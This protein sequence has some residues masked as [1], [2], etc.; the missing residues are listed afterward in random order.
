M[1]P[2]E[3]GVVE[4]RA[5]EADATSVDSDESSPSLEKESHPVSGEPWVIEPR[6][7]GLLAQVREAW[8]YRYLV[9]FFGRKILEK[10][11]KRTKLGFWWLI[12]R[13][14]FPVL[15]STVVFGGV[16][17]VEA[18]GGVPYFLFL[19]AG[20]MQWRSFGSGL[21]W[22]TRSLELNRGLMKQLYFPRLILP[23]ST[24][25]L[26]WLELVIY[27]VILTIAIGYYKVVD[28]I[29][30]LGS[31]LTPLLAL[32]G[33]L[34]GMFFAFSVGLFTSILGAQTRDLRFSLGY[35]LNAWMLLTPVVYP[36]D[37]IP[38]QWRWTVYL[39]PMAAYVETFKFGLLGIGELDVFGLLL[40]V[41][42]T[43]T[44][45]AA[46]LWFFN[47]SAVTSADRL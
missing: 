31:G 47:R 4:A 32:G 15:I 28:G 21:M 35:I 23:F 42:L 36:L 33:V 34:M 13:P 44:L 11:T 9:R 2:H 20:M 30:Y 1:P 16:M 5:R 39:N 43:V 41:V 37:W 25:T 38:Q 19:S 12:I 29:L 24:M 8:R 45:F 3:T 26:A 14:V 7:P 27:V 6:A 18:P 22:C 10:R 46:G 40:A 17:G